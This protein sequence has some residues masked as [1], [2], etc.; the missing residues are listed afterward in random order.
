M[1]CTVCAQA[2]EV[3]S[4]P[5]MCDAQWSVKTAVLFAER[6]WQSLRVTACIAQRCEY[7]ARVVA[8]PDVEYVFVL[9]RCA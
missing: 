5:S 1:S 8:S 2:A 3:H 4:A 7:R 9:V 6:R